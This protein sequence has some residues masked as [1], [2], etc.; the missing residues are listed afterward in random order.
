MRLKLFAILVITLIAFFSCKKPDQYSEIPEIKFNNIAIENTYDQLDNP[1]KRV[2][3]NFS[4]I[5]GDGDVGLDTSE[6]YPPYDTSSVYYHNLFITEFEK[7]N[8][9]YE[10][11]DLKVPLNFRIPDIVQEGKN[12]TLK[13]NITLTLDYL[14]PSI[15]D[16]IKYSFYIFDRAFHKS[17]TVSS[18][19]IIL[20]N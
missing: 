3:L 12:K 19:D 2:Y 15:Y 16:T 18:S 6:T 20:N 4:V 10:V 9:V 11:I 17:N 1:I 14:I 5:D 8:G 13:A 7:K